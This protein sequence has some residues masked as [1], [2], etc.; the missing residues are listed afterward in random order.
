VLI[1]SIELEPSG[2]ADIL[3]PDIAKP[4]IRYGEIIDVGP[5]VT[6]VTQGETIILPKGELI[7][8]PLDGQ[9]YI[10]LFDH[11]IVATL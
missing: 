3:L 7:E 10:I 2:E 8:I 11:E 6:N 4:K 5:D 1:K 9:I